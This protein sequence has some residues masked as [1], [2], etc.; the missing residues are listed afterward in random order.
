MLVDLSITITAAV[1]RP[2][3]S[4]F[5]PSKSIGASIIS[6]AGTSGTDAGVDWVAGLVDDIAREEGLRP[7]V[8]RIYSEIAPD[9]LVDLVRAGRVSPL[10]P[11][12]DL[13]EE[14][15][16]RCLHVVGLMGVEPIIAALDAGADVVIGGRATDTAVI[17]P[18]PP[19]TAPATA[20]DRAT[21]GS[22]RGAA[23]SGGR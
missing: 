10:A 1:P 16:L 20:H 19:T 18:A 23:R 15:A 6:C 9:A 4:A 2:E 11:A 8:A 14:V 13:T 17:G 5:N 21:R 3:P 22:R 12:A 7:R